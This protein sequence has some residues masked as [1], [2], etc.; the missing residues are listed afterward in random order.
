LYTQLLLA[1]P[2]LTLGIHPLSLPPALSRHT[3]IPS[4]V[5]SPP[6]VE[7]VLPDNVALLG[8]TLMIWGD[9]KY[10]NTICDIIVDKKKKPD[11][12]LYFP[13]SVF[14]N[15]MLPFSQTNS[16][17]AQGKSNHT[18][19]VAKTIRIPYLCRSFPAKEPYD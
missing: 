16:T 7:V 12:V 14:K 1:F 15:G 3:P 4:S 11:P 6:S 9:L 18:Y 19:R 13:R 5:N 10:S 8:T 2:P 17:Q